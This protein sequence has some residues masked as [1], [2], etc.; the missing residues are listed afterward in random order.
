MTRPLRER[1]YCPYELLDFRVRTY[2]RIYVRTVRTLTPERTDRAAPDATVCAGRRALSRAQAPARGGRPPS[3]PPSASTYALDAVATAAGVLLA[4]SALLGGADHDARARVPRRD[5]RRLGGRPAREPARELGAARGDRHEHQ[6]AVEGRARPRSARGAACARA[7][8]PS[9]IGYV[10]TEIAKEVPY[11]AGAFG[12][13]VLSDSVVVDRRAR[14]PRRREPR[15]RRLRVRARRRRPA[16]SCAAASRRTRRST[17]TGCRSDYLTDYYS[18]VEPDELETIAFFV[19]AI[20]TAA[21]GEPRA[22]LRRRPDAPPRVPGRGRALRDPPRRLPAGEPAR[23][24]ALA[25]PRP[26]R[27]R[28]AAVRPLHARVRRARLPHRRARS[29]RA[30]S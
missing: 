22:V 14:L 28:L 10:G 25:R 9:A 26:G 24:P 5:L 3:S 8:S 11:Y 7:G 21:P 12:A 16:R 13:A 17:P 29:G 15:R 19:D 4:A 18:E 1:A 2:V 20:E 30:R 27:P 23:D 6:R